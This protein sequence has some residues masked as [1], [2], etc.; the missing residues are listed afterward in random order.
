MITVV[1]GKSL[2]LNFM[3]LPTW[4]GQNSRFKKQM[5]ADLASKIQGL[6][7]TESNLDKVSEMVLDYIVEK[8]PIPGLWDY[9]DGLKFI[10]DA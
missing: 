7:L 10:T 6:E 8:H 5:E 4:L 3:W 9:L 2:E 1:D